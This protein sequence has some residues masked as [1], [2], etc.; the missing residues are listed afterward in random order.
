MAVVL[1]SL[2]V[3]KRLSD[4]FLDNAHSSMILIE[5]LLRKSTI[6]CYWVPDDDYRLF[7]G[8]VIK[9]VNFMLCSPCR[10]SH[11]A[12]THRFYFIHQAS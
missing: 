8:V 9:N 3:K 12:R 1:Q 11:G 10:A 5:L 7:F 2:F 4:L 6:G